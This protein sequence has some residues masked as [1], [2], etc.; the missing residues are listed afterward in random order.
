MPKHCSFPSENQSSVVLR[1]AN[2]FFHHIFRM[3]RK[4]LEK[5]FAI[6]CSINRILILAE[7]L[8]ALTDNDSANYDVFY[9]FADRCASSMLNMLDHG[10]Y[11]HNNATLIAII[12]EIMDLRQVCDHDE[13]DGKIHIAAFMRRHKIR[14][15]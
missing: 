4:V 5:F 10:G 6:G 1:R 8:S 12:M 15:Y 2:P 3:L 14:E 11:F 9:K 13:E 7:Y